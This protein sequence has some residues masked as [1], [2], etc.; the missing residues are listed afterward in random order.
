MKPIITI[1][2]SVSIATI[3]IGVLFTILMNK[4]LHT[5]NH[6]IN[7]QFT[8][9]PMI[10]SWINNVTQFINKTVKSPG[11]EGN[12]TSLFKMNQNS[13]SN[14]STIDFFGNNGNFLGKFFTQVGKALEKSPLVTTTS[15]D[16]VN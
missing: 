14:A 3:V 7:R 6:E 1:V 15:P 10:N 9:N 4:M 13:T 2:I 12:V 11:F 5:T 8:S 16:R